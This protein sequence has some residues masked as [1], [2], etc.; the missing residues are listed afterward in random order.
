MI[1][2]VTKELSAWGALGSEPKV[3]SVTKGHDINCLARVDEQK[4][5]FLCLIEIGRQPH[6]LR[7]INLEKPICVEFLLNSSLPTR[8]I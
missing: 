7:L 2:G 4:N 8:S 1:L 3:I 5:K 6:W